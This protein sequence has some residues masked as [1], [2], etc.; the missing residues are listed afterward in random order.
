VYT[1]VAGCSG[2][3]LTCVTGAFNAIAS[4]NV[5]TYVVVIQHKACAV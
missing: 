5:I 3:M 1:S 4:L 2:V